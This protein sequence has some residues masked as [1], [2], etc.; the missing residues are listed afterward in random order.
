M[1]ERGGLARGSWRD[2]GEEGKEMS[3][4]EEEH[5]MKRAVFVEG[6]RA[7]KVVHDV[8]CPSLSYFCC[9]NVIA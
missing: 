1:N 9:L 8:V 2:E 4:E 3:T 5:Q 6:L 7:M